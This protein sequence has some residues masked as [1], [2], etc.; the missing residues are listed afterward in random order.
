M[1]RATFTKGDCAEHAGHAIANACLNAM[2]VS[3][4]QAE[5][6]AVLQTA[7]LDMQRMPHQKRACGG[8]AVALVNTLEVGLKNLP[9][10][11][12]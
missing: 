1:S 6:V 9:K 7:L 12:E 2:L 3:T 11:G 8:F 4:S 5:S 10:G